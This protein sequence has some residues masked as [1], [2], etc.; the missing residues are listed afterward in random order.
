MP[1]GAGADVR[2]VHLG[3]EVRLRQV[4]LV[5]GTVKEDT[6]GVQHR[7]HR[8]IADEHT[9]FDCVEKRSANQAATNRT[10]TGPS[11][12]KWPDYLVYDAKC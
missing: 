9:L 5:E 10:G 2:L 11:T 6:P 8:P 4:E 12:G 1:I 7:A 3:D